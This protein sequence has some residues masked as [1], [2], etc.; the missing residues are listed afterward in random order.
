MQLEALFLSRYES[1][2]NQQRAT[3]VSKIDL[4]KTAYSYRTHLMT[5]EPDSFNVNLELYRE[6]REI[7]LGVNDSETFFENEDLLLRLCFDPS[8]DL[9][10]T[11]LKAAAKRVLNNNT[12]FTS[13]TIAKVALAV[14]L[15]AKIINDLAENGCVDGGD[16][17][18]QVMA[19][20]DIVTLDELHEMKE[21]CEFYLDKIC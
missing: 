4:V 19:Y 3:M 6:A 20:N 17:N 2:D 8:F 18:A 5:A 16:Y 12:G 11:V 14:N 13:A 15:R 9:E 7:A 1:L 21:E 10:E